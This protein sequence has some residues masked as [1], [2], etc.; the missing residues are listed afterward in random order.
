MVQEEVACCRGLE[1]GQWGLVGLVGTVEGRTRR[2][3]V[4]VRIGTKMRW[5]MTL[6]WLV[7]C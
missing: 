2:R 1:V 6:R 3:V 4:K 5:T 7:G